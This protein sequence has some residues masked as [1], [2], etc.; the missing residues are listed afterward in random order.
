MRVFLDTNVLVSAF[1]TRGLC[2]DVLQLV[3]SEHSLLLGETV[4]SELKRVLLDKLEVPPRIVAEAE[5]LLRQEAE[6]VSDA[7]VP[8]VRPRDDDD[9]VVLGEALIGEADVLITGDRDLLDIAADASLRIL[10]PREFWEH[11]RSD[12]EE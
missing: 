8:D 2:A 4:S 10:S 7:V 3:L 9:V 12:E 6:I 1:A 5:S 11:L